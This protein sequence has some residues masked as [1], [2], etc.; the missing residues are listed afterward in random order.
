VSALESLR[1]VLPEG[2]RDAKLNLSAVLDGGSLSVPQRL[3][4]AVA[5]AIASRSGA[6]RD[7]LTEEASLRGV[8]AAVLDDARA[9]ASLM[10]MN[11]VYYR[12][13]HMVGKPG[14]SQRPP[15]LRMNRLAQPKTSRTELELACLAVSAIHGCE[16]CVQAHERVVLEGGLTEEQVHDAVRIAAVVHAVAVSLEL[17]RETELAVAPTVRAA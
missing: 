9:A 4:V 7:A 2:A 8:E 15:R 6:L 13:R 5:C 16:A 10:A 14:Y 3:M 17:D 12:F 11:N 1:A